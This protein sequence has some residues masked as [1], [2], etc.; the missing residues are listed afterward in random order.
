MP[1]CEIRLVGPELV[2]FKL[3]K[4]QKNIK[5]FGLINHE[6]I[7]ETLSNFNVGIIPYKVN[8][9]TNSIYPL[10]LNE[11]LAAGLPVIST[12]IKTIS[13]FDR[14]HPNT[15]KIIKNKNHFVELLNKIKKKKIHLNTNRLKL[16][17]KQNTWDKK[18]EN[19]DEKIDQVL[20]EKRFD[21]KSIK[22]ELIGYYHNK[23]IIYIKRLTVIII[24]LIVIYNF[25]IN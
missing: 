25:A 6:K 17:A 8:L 2:D 12:G 11:Y 20:F 10:K 21:R 3:L 14:T 16:I 23:K 13:E 19:F 15:I 24:S 4:R 22:T 18:F 7:P 1:N 5:F 9:F